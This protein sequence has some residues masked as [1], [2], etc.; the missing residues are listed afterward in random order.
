MFELADMQNA[1]Q[2]GNA[3]NPGATTGRVIVREAA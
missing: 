3:R 2:R 1:A